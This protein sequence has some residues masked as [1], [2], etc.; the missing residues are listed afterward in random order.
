M[1]EVSNI[2]NLLVIMVGIK[3]ILEKWEPP[4]QKSIQA[5]IMLVVGGCA[6]WFIHPT[7][8]GL[9]TGL[10]GGTVAYWGR[11]IFAQIKDIQEGTQDLRQN[12]KGGK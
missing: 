10:I 5:L 7:K 2:I 3:M 8:E 9:I 1:I 4:F 6:G 12:T 11:G